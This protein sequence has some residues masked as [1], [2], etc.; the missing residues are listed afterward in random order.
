MLGILGKFYRS[1]ARSIDLQKS[2]GE[3]LSILI[4][5]RTSAHPWTHVYAAIPGHDIVAVYS[6]SCTSS[7]C[8]VDPACSDHV[9]DLPFSILKSMRKA[10]FVLGFF[11]LEGILKN[12]F[13]VLGEY[14][15]SSA[16][17]ARKRIGCVR[18]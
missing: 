5:L 2:F 3:I 10:R 1:F 7:T 13:D 17:N 4:C 12:F 16:G 15:R 11:C 9:P 14:F 18:A 8:S 6:Q